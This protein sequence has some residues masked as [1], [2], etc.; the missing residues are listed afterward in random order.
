MQKNCAFKNIIRKKSLDFDNKWH[1]K[2]KQNSSFKK[3]SGEGSLCALSTSVGLM[4]K[5]LKIF[6]LSQ[7][8]NTTIFK[9][10]TKTEKKKKISGDFKFL[11]SHV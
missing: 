9:Q 5:S 7:N 6:N 4:V 3:Y 11:Q 8:S 1:K 10:A 2:A